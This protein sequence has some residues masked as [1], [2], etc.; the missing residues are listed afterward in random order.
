MTDTPFTQSQKHYK[1][2]GHF[3]M[4]RVEALCERGLVKFPGLKSQDL[5]T[6]KKKGFTRVQPVSQFSVNGARGVPRVGG[7]EEGRG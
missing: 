2:P 3:F 4:T 7:A 6:V 1:F 5:D